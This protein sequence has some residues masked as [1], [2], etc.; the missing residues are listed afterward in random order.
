MRQ[1]SQGLISWRFNLLAGENI[2]ARVSLRYPSCIP[3]R[4]LPDEQFGTV[5]KER[6][7]KSRMNNLSE[8]WDELE[9]VTTWIRPD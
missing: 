3:Y 5:L 7:E 1:N 8:T 6:G 4:L 9:G 2:Y